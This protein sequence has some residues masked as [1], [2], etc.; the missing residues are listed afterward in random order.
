MIWHIY[1]CNFKKTV[2]IIW[3]FGHKLQIQKAVLPW[4]GL[5]IGFHSIS[6]L[7]FWFQSMQNM[8]RNLSFHSTFIKNRWL[9]W[10]NLAVST[11][12]FEKKSLKESHFRILCLWC[13]TQNKSKEDSC[14]NISFLKHIILG[15][16]EKAT[17]VL[18]SLLECTVDN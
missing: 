1:S 9:H 8:F 17:E 11:V 5:N 12:D 18:Q 14:V 6:F 4:L 3:I 13:F 16:L 10:V 2:E 7:H 15:H